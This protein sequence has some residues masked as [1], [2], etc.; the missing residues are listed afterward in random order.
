MKVVSPVQTPEFEYFPTLTKIC[1]PG[2]KYPSS[3][4]FFLFTSPTCFIC[5]TVFQLHPRH[6]IKSYKLIETTTAI[7]N[8]QL[9]IMK[10]LQVCQALYD[11]EARTT[12]EIS[13]KESDTLYILAKEDDDWWKAELKQASTEGPAMIGLVPATYMDEVSTLTFTIVTS[14]LSNL[15]LCFHIKV[16]PIGKVRA[17]YDYDAQQEEELSFREGQT[18]W[19]LECD[20]PDWYLVKLDNGDIGLSPANYVHAVDQ[21][22]PPPPTTSAP[23]STQAAVAP[24]MHTKQV[25]Q[26]HSQ[27]PNS[28]C[29]TACQ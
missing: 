14:F 6:Y 26:I 16:S 10:Y 20:D 9:T 18:M 15:L 1:T 7:A 2:C 23:S 17:E 25:I 13:I 29:L 11:Y 22:Q 24:P 4:L 19:L 3:S 12:D 27:L 28:A 5:Y 21:N 8:L